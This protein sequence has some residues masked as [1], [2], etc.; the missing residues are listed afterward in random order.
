MSNKIVV[1]YALELLLTEEVRTCVV[2]S[3]GSL[4]SWQE[5]R[6]DE[7]VDFNLFDGGAGAES[8]ASDC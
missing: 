1:L 3:F 4:R 7:M 6:V 5:L 8:E 2:L